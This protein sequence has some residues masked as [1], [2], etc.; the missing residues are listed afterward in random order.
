[1][2]DSKAAAKNLYKE[3]LKEISMD[4]VIDNNAGKRS[5]AEYVFNHVFDCLSSEVVARS[6]L[7]AY[8]RRRTGDA[9]FD[10]VNMSTALLS[11]VIAIRGEGEN[12]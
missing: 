10:F 3:D 12:T 7:D 4:F 5:V 11:A 6:V 9:D 2:K 8:E 1:M